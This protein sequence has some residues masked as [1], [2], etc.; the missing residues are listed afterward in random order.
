MMKVMSQ[1]QI[2]TGW[3]LSRWQVLW[4]T[5]ARNNRWQRTGGLN[6]S[7]SAEMSS[8]PFCMC[9]MSYILHFKEGSCSSCCLNEC[10][11]QTPVHCYERACICKNECVTCSIFCSVLFLSQPLNHL[12]GNEG[13]YPHKSQFSLFRALCCRAAA[14]Q[15]LARC[16]NPD[17]PAISVWMQT[18]DTKS[19][20]CC[21]TIAQLLQA[22]NLYI[23]ASIPQLKTEHC[24]TCGSTSHGGGIIKQRKGQRG[25]TQLGNTFTQ[26]HQRLF[27]CR[28]RS[29]LRLNHSRRGQ[30]RVSRSEQEVRQNKRAAGFNTTWLV[31]SREPS[32]MSESGVTRN[33]IRHVKT[34]RFCWSAVVTGRKPDL[35]CVC[36]TLKKGIR[37]VDRRYGER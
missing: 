16:S 34:L 3:W 6:E 11:R 8:G 37:E 2:N 20:C 36:T 13:S 29:L 30:L 24:L 10:S 7:T 12:S 15:L 28:W 5:T 21:V 17:F 18:C 25:K 26:P 27:S 33:C 19:L 35:K 1:I 9:S 14:A 4:L 22:R 23:Y 31:L 32:V